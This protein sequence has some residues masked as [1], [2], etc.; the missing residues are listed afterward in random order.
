MKIKEDLLIDELEKKEKQIQELDERLK[1]VLMKNETLQSTLKSLYEKD[2][3]FM[4]NI[5]RENEERDN[6]LRLLQSELDKSTIQSYVVCFITIFK[7]LTIKNNLN[8]RTVQ[9]FI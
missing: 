6:S 9:L 7:K 5:R 1:Q 2:D 4:A 8:Y 3:V